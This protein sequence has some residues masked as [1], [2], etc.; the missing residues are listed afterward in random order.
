MS[1]FQQAKVMLGDFVH[2]G[3]DA[4]H[5]YVG[6]GLFFG[7]ALILGW[8]L[9]GWR[10][11]LLALAG[12]LGGEMLDLFDIVEE[13]RRFAWLAQFKDVANTIFWPTIIMLLARHTRVLKRS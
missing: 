4:L 8:R 5:V 7:S 6:L 3:K 12:A 13:G 1:P 11:W 2:L 10:P 9:S